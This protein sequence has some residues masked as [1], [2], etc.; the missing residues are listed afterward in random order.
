LV[1]S[2]IHIFI[3]SISFILFS[4]VYPIM[5]P[6]VQSAYKGVAQP[7]VGENGYQECQCGKSEALP[8]GWNGFNAKPLKSDIHIDHD[9]EIVMRDGVRLYADV[10]RPANSTEKIP[11]VLSWSFYGK[12]YSALDMLC[13]FGNAVSHH[14][15]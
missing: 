8:A 1:V 4:Y 10:Y 15:T 3:S 2:P 7:K 14:P 5:P 9:V 6:P 11:A 13:A 12:K